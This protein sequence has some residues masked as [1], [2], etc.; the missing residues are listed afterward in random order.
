TAQLHSVIMKSSTT[1]SVGLRPNRVR[2]AA[3]ADSGDQIPSVRFKRV[4]GTDK[5][6]TNW[7]VKLADSHYSVWTTHA[8]QPERW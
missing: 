8:G 2:I 7:K 6:S 5:G 3:V 4:F 1:V